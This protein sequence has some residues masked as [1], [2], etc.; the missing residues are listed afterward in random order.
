M[1]KTL[2]AIA[3]LAALGL[4]GGATYA[5]DE[6]PALATTVAMA[7]PSSTA[8]KIEHILL[9]SAWNVK[10]YVRGGNQE[11][12]FR[13]EGNILKVDILWKNSKDTMDVTIDDQGV[14]HYSWATGFDVQLAYQPDKGTFSGTSTFRQNGKSADMKLEKKS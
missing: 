11:A 1:S 8:E 3:F 4:F 7:T 6:T 5:A 9:S 12:S 13:K 10:I 14:V 2:I